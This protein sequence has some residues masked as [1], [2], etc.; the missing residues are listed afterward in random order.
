MSLERIEARERAEQSP[1][2]TDREAVARVI[3]PALAS[4]LDSG[5]LNAWG[6]ENWAK[7]LMKADQILSLLAPSNT[8][9]GQGWNTRSATPVEGELVEALNYL[10][11]QLPGEQPDR[12]AIGVAKAK[13]ALSQVRP[14][15]PEVE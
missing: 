7:V 2:S 10:L 11:S 15:A 6:H 4:L 13:R 3:D 8:Q 12:L 1:S 14:Q 5:G 9:A